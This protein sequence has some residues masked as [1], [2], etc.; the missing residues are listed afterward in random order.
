MNVEF[1]CSILNIN[2][3]FTKESL[4]KAYLLAALEY[5]PDKNNNPNANSIFQNITEAYNYLSNINN[6]K[7][8]NFN[9]FNKII[10]NDLI[11]Q[12][13]SIS[14][15]KIKNIEPEQINNLIKCFKNNCKNFSFQIIKD[16]NPESIFKIYE[17]IHKFKDILNF[18]S[19]TLIIIEDIIKKKLENNTIIILNPTLIN[20]L[21]NDTFKL[22]INEEILYVPLWKD[23]SIFT[24]KNN[25]ILY[26]KCIPDLPDNITIM[27]ED[28]HIN[29]Y[30][31]LKSILISPVEINISYNKIII[32]IEE[33][34]IKNYQKFIFKNKGI[35]YLND[36]LETIF[37][38]SIIVH[39]FIDI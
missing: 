25:D 15:N 6:N 37:I 26:I 3:P 35:N 10:Y 18:S 23:L 36:K 29:I 22:N 2:L 34:K 14:L 19:D 39:I 21:N 16:L 32:P 5:H 17:Y 28:I 27:N 4:R 13:I 33:L 20:I 9:N 8:N 31:T 11:E 24:L 1:A 12:F 7:E 38:G 30:T